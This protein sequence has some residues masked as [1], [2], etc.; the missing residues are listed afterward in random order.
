M[1][2]FTNL[3]SLLGGLAKAMNLI[4]PDME[5]HHEQTAYLA[6]LIARE[7]KFSE[8]DVERTIC[9]ALLHDIGSIMFEKQYSVAEIEHHSQVISRLGAEMLRDVKGMEKIADIIEHCQSSWEDCT[10]H[11]TGQCYVGARIASVIHLSD[12]VSLSVKKG[13]PILNQSKRI[14][15][16]IESGKGTEFSEEAVE[17]FLRIAKLEFVWFDLVYNPSFL[18]MFFTGDIRTLSLDQTVEITKVM[19]RIIDYR[20]AFTAM[21]SAGVAASAVKLAK[22]SGMSEENCKKMWIAGYLL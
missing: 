20:S 16:M 9:A 19:S 4:N 7:L 13:Q 14:C 6:Y 2:N 22:L 11:A 17:V 15:D 12:V 3:R 21:H 1:E 5:N 8:K 10:D 18:L